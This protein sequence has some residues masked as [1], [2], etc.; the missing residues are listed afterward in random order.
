MRVALILAGLMTGSIN[1]A[2][3]TPQVV[4][5][6]GAGVWGNVRLVEDKRIGVLDGDD[7]YTF[8][9]IRSILV[10]RDG[11]I[12]VAEYGRPRVHI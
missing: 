2:A 5:S 9:R 6:T 3:Q 4:R 11:S 10:A 12:W 1:A 7:A 8:G